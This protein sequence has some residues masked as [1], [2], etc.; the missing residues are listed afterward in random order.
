MGER[1]WTND[2]IDPD[3][4]ATFGADGK[5]G[6]NAFNSYWDVPAIDKAVT[7]ARQTLDPTARQSLY[8]TI[9]QEVYTQTPFLVTDYSPFRYGIGNWVHGFAVT[10]LGNYDLS[11]EQLTVDNH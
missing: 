6:A 1:Y 4:V 7:Q 5:G 3:E 8:N 11:L 10:P 2:I 9:Q